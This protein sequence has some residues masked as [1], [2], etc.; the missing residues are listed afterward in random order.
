[1]A[2]G[3]CRDKVKVESF[4]GVIGYLSVTIGFGRALRCIAT[5]FGMHDRDALSLQTSYSDKKIK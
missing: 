3:S 4:P 5:R 1:M 2:E